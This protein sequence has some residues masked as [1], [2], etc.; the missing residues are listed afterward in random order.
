M[1]KEFRCPY[2]DLVNGKWN[3]KYFLHERLPFYFKLND[4]GHILANIQTK[5]RLDV[6]FKR[7]FDFQQCKLNELKTFKIWLQSDNCII[8]ISLYDVYLSLIRYL[9]DDSFEDQLFG[10]NS[11]SLLGPLGPFSDISLITC[12][13]EEIIHHFIFKYSLKNKLC[14]R[15]LR[16]RTEGEVKVQ[17]GEDFNYSA[18]FNVKQITDCG[19][20]FS[21][22]DE[23]YQ[24]YQANG[25]SIKIFLDPSVLVSVL[26]HGVKVHEDHQHYYTNS[27]LNYFIIDEGKMNKSLSFN[28]LDTNEL[29]LFC[30]YHHMRE[31]HIPSI[32]ERFISNMKYK[33]F[34]IF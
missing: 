21:T 16:V 25:S 34:S 19:I 15:K 13:N 23:F 8:K 28:S 1:R 2:T 6:E 18:L 17:Y 4:C 12:L 27:A 7:L 5:L 33:I 24:Q 32:C 3:N 26:E 31:S 9:K 14:H 11:I 20:L 22:T 10:L 29:Y 30:R